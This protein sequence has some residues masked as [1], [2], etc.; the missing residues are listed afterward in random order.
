MAPIL[1]GF[2]AKVPPGQMG[3]P[4]PGALYPCFRAWSPLKLPHQ[5]RFWGVFVPGGFRRPDDNFIRRYI[6][7]T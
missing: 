6:C 4:P 2:A 3:H 1:E 5:A 7:G